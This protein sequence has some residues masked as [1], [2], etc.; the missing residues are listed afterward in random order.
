MT[1]KMTYIGMDDWDR[2]VYRDEAERLWKDTDPRPHVPAS[3]SRALNDEFHG[4][5]CTPFPL[6]DKPVFLPKRKTW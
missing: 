3:L 5:P 1:V 2:P 6:R 4:E